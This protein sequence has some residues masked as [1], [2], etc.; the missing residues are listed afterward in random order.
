MSLV[1]QSASPVPSAPLPKRGCHGEAVTGG[2]FSHTPCGRPPPHRILRAKTAGPL[3]PPHNAFYFLYIL[4]SKIARIPVSTL[5]L[6]SPC[7][8]LLTPM[9]KVLVTV[10]WS[11]SY[12]VPWMLTPVH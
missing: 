10:T 7:H 1:W 9:G 11:S 3:A 4:D 8:W 5:I 2:F 12:L 6:A